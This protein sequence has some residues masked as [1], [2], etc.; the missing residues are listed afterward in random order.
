ME[1]TDKTEG[2]M[3]L[4]FG[5]DNIIAPQNEEQISLDID[6]NGVITALT[7]GIQIMR[8]MFG[9][10]GDAL[11]KDAIGEDG[12]RSSA[13]LI[14]NY[15]DAAGHTV[16]DLDGNGIVRALSDGIL[17]IRFL[18]GFRGET[19]TNGA[20]APGAT[21]TTAAEIEQLIEQLNTLTPTPTDP[22]DP[23]NTLNTAQALGTLNRSR[24][25]TLSDSVGDA[26]SVDM[27]SFSLDEVSDLNFTLSGM[28]ADA[29]L[30][31]IED[32]N[33][34]G[35]EDEEYFIVGFESINSG[36]SQ[37][38]ISGILQHGDYFVVV[39]QHSGDTNYELTLDASPVV[40]PPDNAGNTLTA[41]REIGTL[42]DRQTF[43]DFVGDADPEDFYRFSLDSA[44]EFN[45]TLE[46]LSSDA[47]V[48]LIED[49][50]GNG[51][52]D[53]DEILDAPFNEG[54]DS[55][56]I[57]Q[58]LFAG[59]YFVL[60]EQFEG[61]TNYDLSLEAVPVTVRPDN[62]GNT[63][64]TARDLGILNDRQTF[65]DFVDNADPYDFYLFTLEDTSELN[66]TLEG[67]SSD[68]DVL[69]FEDF[70]GNGLLDDDEI[71]DAPFN[72]GSDSEEIN[73]ILFAG[74]Y[75]V[76][77]EQF[78]GNTN[79]DLSLEAVPVTVRPDNAGN[80]LDT[81]RDLG[82]LN[83]RQTF[84]DFVDNADPYDFY[85]FTLEDT[86]EL[87]LTLEG[88]SSD[89]DVLLFEDFNGNGLLDDDEI[90][91]APFNEGSDSEEINQIL[92]AGDYFVL[93]EQFEGNTNYD[94]SLE[95]VPVTVRPDNAGN[96]IATARNIGT[97]SEPQT[98]ND[99]VGNA[100]QSDV[101]RF[102][103]DTISDFSLR[104]DGL[105][106]DADADVSLIED[107]N[108]NGEMDTEE[109]V[110]YSDNTGNNPEEIE[111]VLQSGNYFIVVD[112]FEG[113]TNYALTV[114]ATPRTE[115]PPD[116]AGNTL[117][118]AR[119]IGTL[120]ETVTFNDFVGDV[121]WEDIYR[122]NL[123][124]TSSFNLTLGGLTADAGVYVARDDNSDGQV[125]LD[126]IV[127]SSQ[128]GIGDSEVISLEGLNAGE[129]FIVVEEAGG[130]TDYALTLE[131]TPM[132][133]KE[134]RMPDEDSTGKYHR[135]FGYGL[136]DA[137][138]A[139]ASAAGARSFPGV[140]DLTG[141]ATKNNAGDLN[142]INVPEVWAKGFTG[143]GVVVAVLDTGVDY[144]HPDLADNIWTN[145]DEIPG[146]GIDDD[147]NGF[148]DDVNGWD[149]VDNDNDP[150]DNGKK[151]GHGT[152]VAGTIAALRN[153]AQT[154]AN[155]SEVDTVGVA[156]N[157]KI[158]PVR[159]LGDGPGA[160]DAVVNGIRYAVANGADVINMSLGADGNDEE[161]SEIKEMSPE[162]KEALQFAKENNVVVA[163]ASGNERQHYTPM[164][165]P[166]V[167][168]L[169]AEDDLAVAVGAVDHRDLVYTDFS[170]PAGLPQLDYVVAPGKGVLSLLPSDRTNAND[171]DAWSGTSMAAPHVA[172][173]MALML[174]A[175]PNLTPDRVADILINTASLDG[176]TDALA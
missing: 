46:G 121:D 172:G 106:A 54:S 164:T 128:E 25:R 79:Y 134:P 165:R 119:D 174:Q 167:P 66:L 60:V 44:S 130:D 4:G 137:A 6:G 58:I 116:E 92:F 70:N 123:A 90:L 38:E 95:A 13:D 135:I 82:I 59:D 43:S 8:Y 17:F 146:N 125:M 67:L 68:A 149:F 138:A 76:L 171:I 176:I 115:V 75:F 161:Q 173:V 57:N 53:D 83:D 15:L 111:Q 72:E 74:D 94:L 27:Y 34:N 155:G 2:D 163:I 104:L 158:M 150:Q 49:I 159:V 175:N 170:N 39:E 65:S 11:T 10:R 69:L 97:L 19:L 114:E 93:V 124:T 136:I 14:T 140:D 24:A 160:A 139:V 33:G 91:D 87:N 56:E 41:A 5:D 120:E 100:D 152:H 129:Y 16:L 108:N 20:I 156:Y 51:L 18:F 77:V 162:Y 168:A 80:T 101:Y 131:A 169:F 50:N 21:R 12:T 157:A 40:A 99:F 47:D 55:E 81:A 84:S 73:Q 144:K 23:G 105:S 32:T 63:L 147:N 107:A 85:L 31:I 64:D 133:P 62:A 126:E 154:D 7:D 122:F 112:Q 9:F 109:L 151:P 71:L 148:V 78:E 127:A 145:T 89:A 28:N 166:G 36:N 48:L 102:S 110:Y 141:A 22:T 118:T 117:A 29:D 61:N 37:E 1:N 45:L 96:T 3:E 26:D 88:L 52:L 153:G 86:S 98:F 103:L 132:T 113:N 142:I 42:N 143:R 35:Q 30:F